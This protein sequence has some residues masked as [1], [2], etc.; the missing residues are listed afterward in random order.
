[1]HTRGTSKMHQPLAGRFEKY[2]AV[3][4]SSRETARR[5]GVSPDHTMPSPG[6]QPLALFR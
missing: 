1:M 4:G 6:T 2:S 5:L 3:S